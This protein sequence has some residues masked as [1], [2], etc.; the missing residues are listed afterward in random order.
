MVEIA[1]VVDSITNENGLQTIYDRLQ[2]MYSVER[3]PRRNL[4][5]SSPQLVITNQADTLSEIVTTYPTIFILT[6]ASGHPVLNTTTNRRRLLTNPLKLAKSV[7]AYSNFAAKELRNTYKIK[8]LVQPPIAYARTATKLDY[9]LH[10]DVP[11]EIRQAFPK[12]KF[13]EYQSLIDFKTASLYID[14][15]AAF[16]CFNIRLC[17]AATFGVPCVA[18]HTVTNR[19]AA[20]AGDILLPAKA[21][22]Q[23]W[24]NTIKVAMRDRKV[25]SDKNKESIKRFQNTTDLDREIKRLLRKKPIAGVL[26]KN[27][28]FHQNKLVREKLAKLMKVKKRA[29]GQI[30]MGRRETTKEKQRRK[31]RFMRKAKNKPKPTGY[32]KGKI[33]P[34]TPYEVK[35]TPS[36]FT[37]H[38]AADVSIIVPMFRSRNHIEKQINTWDLSD[39]GLVKEVVYVDDACPVKSHEIIL[40]TWEERRQELKGNPIGKIVTGDWNRGYGP[41]CNLGA[42]CASGKYLVFLNADAQVLP[43]WVLPMYELFQNDPKVGIVGNLQL[44]P[45]CDRQYVDSAGSEFMWSGGHFEHIGRNIYHGTRLKQPFTLDRLP[46]D[47]M[48][49]GQREMVTGCCFMIPR[50]LFLQLGGY[51]DVY[52]VAYWE[53]SDMNMAVREK[54]FKILFQPASKII[55]TGGHSRAHGHKFNKQN[56]DRFYFRWVESGF[57]DEIAHNRRPESKPRPNKRSIRDCVDGEVVGCV[58]ACNEEEFLEASVRS[59]APIVDR[60]IF[61]IGG[62]QYAY[63]S[64]MCDARGYPTDST[65]QIARSL[66]KQFNGT[67]IEPP[68][69]LW[70]GK[71]EMRNSY[72]KHLKPGNWMFMLDGDEV[73]KEGQL[74]VLAKKMQRYECLRLQYYVFWNNVET[75]GTGQW[76]SYPQER[77]VKWREGYQYKAPNHLAVSNSDGAE[78]ANRVPT[79]YSDEKFF[80]HYSW[81]RP[82]EK[83]RQKMM[84]YQHQL[85]DEWNQKCLSTDY[86]DNVFLRWRTD[87]EGVPETHPR[88]GGTTCQFSGIH[89]YEVTKLIRAGKLDF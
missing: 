24:I 45:I 41:S 89:P 72:A 75:L 83:I 11:E 10:S 9:I 74:W 16:E 70:R 21:K 51:D 43:N 35:D 77:I 79:F 71:T 36:W 29:K 34:T 61:V 7:V 37:H 84:Y 39:D 15:T 18:S 67:V 20:S 1:F 60:F 85:K 66:G 46:P 26:P 49:V 8:A 40:P 76:E 82:I 14:K 53:D 50:E 30:I 62:N 3:L 4:K 48:K 2:T 52:K 23:E 44:K 80:Y 57:I 87:P 65:L 68:G 6:D 81:V 42:K 69:R 33:P 22:N 38:G 25:N 19:E 86:V 47:L 5:R 64:G 27:S 88:G 56:K 54:G 55:H 12:L 63:R 59:I 78:V 31:K 17:H 28:T 58:I 73:Y 13:K 32:D